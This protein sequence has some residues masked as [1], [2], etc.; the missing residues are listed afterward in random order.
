MPPPPFRHTLRVTTSLEGDVFIY[1][2][3]CRRPPS[4]LFAGTVKTFAFY[5]STAAVA[6][7]FRTRRLYLCATP[8][9]CFVFDARGTTRNQIRR[10]P[11]RVLGRSALALPTVSVAMRYIIQFDILFSLVFSPRFFSSFATFSPSIAILPH[12]PTTLVHP[13]WCRVT[14]CLDASRFPVPGSIGLLGPGL[15]RFHRHL[16]FVP[17]R[18]I[19]VLQL[20]MLFCHR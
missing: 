13:P 20:L 14:A 3:R 16:S 6:C 4:C 5:P 8:T 11:L 10:R 9:A 12:H 2:L 17:L 18:S 15:R 7:L 1:G 19:V